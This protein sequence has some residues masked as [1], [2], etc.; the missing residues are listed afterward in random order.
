MTSLGKLA[1]GAGVIGTVILGALT[2]DAPLL[3]SAV[4]LAAVGTGILVWIL[5]S[6]RRVERLNVLLR[7]APLPVTGAPGLARPIAEP[8]LAEAD[9]PL[10]DPQVQAYLAQVRKS[11]NSVLADE[12]EQR[13][14]QLANEGGP[15]QATQRRRR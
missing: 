6:D 1:S 7:G 13:L 3:I 10:Q 4:G 15:R 5:S 8:A 2:H 9:S 11:G 14:A 12:L